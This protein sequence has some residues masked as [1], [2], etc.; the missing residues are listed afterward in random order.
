MIDGK[1]VVLGSLRSS[2]FAEVVCGKGPLRNLVYCVTAEG[3]LCSFQSSRELV[4][5]I[6]LEVASA[7]SLAVYENAIACG[8]SDG[9]IRVLTSDFKHAVTLPKPTTPAL[10]YERNIPLG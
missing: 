7:H 1:A 8:C 3:L 9:T 5:F 10:E 2:N 4:H 6:E